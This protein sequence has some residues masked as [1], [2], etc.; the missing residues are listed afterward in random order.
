MI[1]LVFLLI[2]I[3]VMFPR[4]IPVSSSYELRRP[5]TFVLGLSI[6]L[7][8]GFWFLNVLENVAWDM[9]WDWDY[10][11]PVIVAIVIGYFLKQKINPSRI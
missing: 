9:A 11:F 8:S 6:V 2:G 7:L 5:R 10:I 3:L 4:R 1:I